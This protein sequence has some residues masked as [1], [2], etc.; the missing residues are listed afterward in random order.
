MKG[1]TMALFALPAEMAI[2]PFLIAALL[3][4]LGMREHAKKLYALAFLVALAP[5]FEPLLDALLRNIPIWILVAFLFWFLLS[6]RFV[7]EV[8]T[9][10]LGHLLA[11]AIKFLLFLPFR[12][13][14]LVIR[15][16]VRRRQ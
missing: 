15:T 1:M 13:I 8:L 5:L 2:F 9:R 6:F 7:R 10:A 3:L 11:E 12:I 14:G 16:V 4:I